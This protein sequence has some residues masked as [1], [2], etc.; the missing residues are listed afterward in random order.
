MKTVG[1]KPNLPKLAKA[2]RIKMTP[3]GD[4]EGQATNKVL[5][6]DKKPI[7]VQDVV[8]GYK[9]LPTYG[10]HATIGDSVWRVALRGPTKYHLKVL[11]DKKKMETVGAQGF[12]P[13][14][15]ELDYGT[16]EFNEYEEY[17]AFLAEKGVD[18]STD[19]EFYASK[20]KPKAGR[21]KKVEEVA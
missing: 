3:S 9:E 18:I 1:G 19:E 5:F 10:G 13:S 14:A 15:P 6:V 8:V 17:K 7:K 4:V 2:G 21:P 20:N 12:R 16:P 11:A